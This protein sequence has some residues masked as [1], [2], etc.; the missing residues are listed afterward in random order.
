MDCEE[1]DDDND[2]SL[3]TKELSAWVTLGEVALAI[4]ES[5][6][7]ATVVATTFCELY[8]LT[9]ESMEEV[10]VGHVADGKEKSERKT[11]SVPCKQQCQKKKKESAFVLF[12]SGFGTHMFMRV[13]V[14][15][16]MC[17]TYSFAF[18]FFSLLCMYAKRRQKETEEKRY[19]E[20][21]TYSIKIEV[22]R[23]YSLADSSSVAVQMKRSYPALQEVVRK[24]ALE[25]LTKESEQ[26]DAEVIANLWKIV[27]VFFCYN[28]FFQFFF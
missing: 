5:K 7:T 26:R 16:C 11:R 14:Y 13:C 17:I 9:Q 20:K 6:R 4:P 1:I 18:F 10:T 22:H 28:Y 27:F 23:K 21:N 12:V 15:V 8:R 3:V 25:V 24:A 19:D 2:A